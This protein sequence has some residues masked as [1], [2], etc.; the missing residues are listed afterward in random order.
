MLVNIVCIYILQFIF[1]ADKDV[2]HLLQWPREY[3]KIKDL[4]KTI[5]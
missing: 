1:K 2:H 3:T 5:E 4:L